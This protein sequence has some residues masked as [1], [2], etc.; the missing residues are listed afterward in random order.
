MGNVFL[1]GQSGNDKQ[2]A[3]GEYGPS[4]GNRNF[5]SITVSLD[6]DFKPDY[7]LLYLYKFNNDSPSSTSNYF[8]HMLY[9]VNNETWQ[10]IVEYKEYD[11]TDLVTLT[12]IYAIGYN[13]VP[14]FNEENKTF[15]TGKVSYVA[16]DNYGNDPYFASR[17]SFSSKYTYRWIAWKE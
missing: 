7:I 14:T 17:M 16:S 8:Q 12:N 6:C 11:N 15:Y 4:S 5:D 9:D 3:T 1:A 2:I 13:E 10:T